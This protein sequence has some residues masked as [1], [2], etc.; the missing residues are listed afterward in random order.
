MKMFMTPCAP[1][2]GGAA[3][4]RPKTARDPR[5]GRILRVGR[6]P[7]DGE[8]EGRVEVVIRVGPPSNRRGQRDYINQVTASRLGDKAA[9]VGRV[10]PEPHRVDPGQ[11]IV[12]AAPG[13]SYTA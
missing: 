4:A 9:R 13:R 2:G 6:G 3:G 10:V 1:S 8:S 5:P 11:R 12:G 7:G